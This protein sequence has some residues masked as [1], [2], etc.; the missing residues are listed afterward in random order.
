MRWPARGHVGDERLAVLVE[1]LRAGGDLQDDV[2]A[3]AAGAVLAHAV[4]AV[5]GLEMLLVAVVDERVQ[6]LDALGEDVAAAAA[7]AAVRTAE[8]DEFFPAKR[9]ASRR[10]RRRSG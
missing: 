6:A 1:D 2:L 7:V 9:D 3:L 10:R 8:L 4:A 5:L